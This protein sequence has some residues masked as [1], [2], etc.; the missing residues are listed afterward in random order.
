M[1]QRKKTSQLPKE[2][3]C[4]CQPDIYQNKCFLEKPIRAFVRTEASLQTTRKESRQNEHPPSYHPIEAKTITK[5]FCKTRAK[6]CKR[7]H[8]KEHKNIIKEGRAG[9]QLGLREM[10]LKPLAESQSKSEKGIANILIC[11]TQTSFYLLK[12]NIDVLQ[13]PM[14]FIMKVAT[15]K[16][17]Q[18]S[19]YRRNT[20]SVLQNQSQCSFQS[21]GAQHLK[22]RELQEIHIRFQTGD[23]I[24][25]F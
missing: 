25:T 20:D 12:Y 16:Y 24:Y 23:G 14:Q 1:A 3:S 21:K 18:T 10:Q 2:T 17:R 6:T 15:F 4:N 7:K 19:S 22:G 5:G 9:Q 11:F 13:S 8:R